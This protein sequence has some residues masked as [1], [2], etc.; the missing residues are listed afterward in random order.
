MTPRVV[1]DNRGKLGLVACWLALVS[2]RRGRWRDRFA[3][4]L[5][6]FRHYERFR[7]GRCCWYGYLHVEDNIAAACRYC[8][9]YSKLRVTGGPL[10]VILY[11]CTYI[12]STLCTYMPLTLYFCNHKDNPWR[13]VVAKLVFHTHT[14]THTHHTHFLLIM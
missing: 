11:S 13:P 6:L 2:Q 14:H 1:V 7:D 9:G 3:R 4:S 5:A 10:I 8:L 12:P